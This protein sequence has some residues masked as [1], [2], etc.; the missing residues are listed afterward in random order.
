MEINVESI[1]VPAKINVN[2]T[3]MYSRIFETSACCMKSAAPVMV[4]IGDA[5]ITSI[6]YGGIQY[7]VNAKPKLY[8]PKIK[9][10]IF[11]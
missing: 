3:T 5:E 2:C 4:I 1:H 8:Q 9:T 10:V 11:I 6:S 7:K